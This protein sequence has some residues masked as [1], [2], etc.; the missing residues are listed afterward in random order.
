[1]HQRRHERQGQD[2]EHD[3]VAHGRD[4]AQA[5]EPVEHPVPLREQPRPGAAGLAPAVL[6]RREHG[7]E[8]RAQRVRVGGLKRD[9]HALAAAISW[10]WLSSSKSNAA[11]RTRRLTLKTV[12]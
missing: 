11:L 4:E 1:M 12:K 10:C 5:L 8:R 3:I 6:A 2:G 7:A 9:A